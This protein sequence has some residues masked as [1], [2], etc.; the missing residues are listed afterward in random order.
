MPVSV[1]DYGGR[2]NAV[3]SLEAEV[4]ILFLFNPMTSVCAVVTSFLVSGQHNSD[5]FVCCNFSNSLCR[6]AICSIR[7]HIKNRYARQLRWVI[8]SKH[9]LFL[10]AIHCL[11]GFTN[12]F[13]FSNRLLSRCTTAPFKV[14]LSI[15]QRTFWL[16]PIKLK[17][18]LQGISS[19]SQWAYKPCEFYS[20]YWLMFINLLT[21]DLAT[22]RP[23]QR[24]WWTNGEWRAW[25]TR[26]ETGH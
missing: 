12:A 1:I 9:S 6:W 10:F 16:E 7:G 17:A 23:L 22:G 19:P 11:F 2:T 3:A 13:Y 4:H 14:L 18:A 5:S 26:Q 21:T 15:G 25:N 24:E 8:K 20:T